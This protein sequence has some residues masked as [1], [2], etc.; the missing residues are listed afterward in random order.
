[1]TTRV[2]VERVVPGGTV[3]RRMAEAM[4]PDDA[5]EAE[6]LYGASL[7]DLLRTSAVRAR[8]AFAATLDGA[9]VAV[10]G[11]TRSPL[12]KPGVPWFVSTPFAREVPRD[13][14][15]GGRH[16]TQRWLRWH[17][18]LANVVSV[19]RSETGRWL[20]RIGFR[21]GGRY[22]TPA[23]VVVQRFWIERA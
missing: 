4:D 7:A 23:G 1:M 13:L 2:V 14:L 11:L 22:E 19:R 9:P 16:F 18:L 20:E 6:R 12:G 5:A 15:R 8:E 21:A 17:P 10:F 3:L